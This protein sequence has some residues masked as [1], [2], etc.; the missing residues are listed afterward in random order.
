MTEAKRRLKNPQVGEISLVD[1]GDNPGADHVLF[2]R[3]G[4]VEKGQSMSM[5]DRFRELLL[6]VKE[7]LG[8]DPGE[9]VRKALYDEVRDESMKETANHVLNRRLDDLSQAFYGTMFFGEEGDGR[10][11]EA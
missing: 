7:K 2:K 1:Y 11:I 6:I 8:G 10:N 5:A 4:G 3:R 9:D